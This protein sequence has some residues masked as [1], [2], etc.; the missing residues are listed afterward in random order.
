MKNKK[1]ESTGNKKTILST[2]F[3]SI[4]KL[5]LAKVLINRKFKIF[6]K[7]NITILKNDKN[8]Y[9]NK[10]SIKNNSIINN[11]LDKNNNVENKVIKYDSTT[12]ASARLLKKITI[13][14]VSL[15]LLSVFV[16]ADGW[17]PSKSSHETIFTNLITSK[18]D[19]ELVTVSDPNGLKV[20]SNAYLATTAGSKV[21]IGTAS[22]LGDFHVNKLPVGTRGHINLLVS[23]GISSDPYNLNIDTN[24]NA[25][26]KIVMSAEDGSKRQA[27]VFSD[28]G[29]D[30]TKT[31]FGVSSSLDSGVSWSPRL[32]ITHAGNVG[33]GTT[34]PSSLLHISA[35]TV[36][37]AEL[38]LEADTDNNNEADNPFITFKQDANNVN[39]FIGLEGNP[40]IRSTGTLTNAFVIGSEDNNPAL[41]F[42]TNDIVRMTI[43]ATNGN[44]GIG[45]ASPGYNLHINKGNGRMKLQGTAPGIWFHDDV[46]GSIA[47]VGAQDST[48]VGFWGSGGGIGWSLL[49]MNTANGNVGIG[50]ATPE[51]KLQVVGYVQLALTAGIPPVA[52]CD[53]ATKEGR[54]KFDSTA[55]LLYICSGVSGWVSK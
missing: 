36:G 33:I 13:M 47:F 11:N 40:G 28:I 39:A 7:N 35:D 4:L 42:V 52:D 30:T 43:K 29:T 5:N 37:D 14:F 8:N 31:I 48:R 53:S 24:V 2:F 38:I 46:G 3:T 20:F 51:S 27:L 22:P 6:N 1:E 10:N 23:D 15:L 16:F 54:M 44:V 19:G 18:T 21:G 41:Q 26:E 17:V 55:N 12:S 34:G 9:N 25:D 50:T 45:T 49:N 32:V